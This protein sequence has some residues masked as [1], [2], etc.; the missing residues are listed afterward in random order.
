MFEAN[1]LVTGH[2]TILFL[3]KVEK[4]VTNSGYVYKG[5]CLS[6]IVGRVPDV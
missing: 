1:K 3:L 5:Y 4:V 6:F 2:F